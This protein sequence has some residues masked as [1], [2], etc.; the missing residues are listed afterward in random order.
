MGKKVKRGY[1]SMEMSYGWE[2]D[3]N[4]GLRSPG[5]KLKLPFSLDPA[6]EPERETIVEEVQ[7][8]NITKVRER[9]KAIEVEKKDEISKLEADRKNV[10]IDVEVVSFEEIKKVGSDAYG[11]PLILCLLNVRDCSGSIPLTLWN[12]DIE[13]ITDGSIQP[14]SIL[15]IRN[16][17]VREFQGKIR[18]TLGR[19][20]QLSI[21]R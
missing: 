8:P 20:G 15:R 9:H 10:N 21:I 6:F 18:L 19:E 17:Y 3:A 5:T 12:R 13:R 7:R 14:S 1:K 4:K 2:K 16:G 11:K